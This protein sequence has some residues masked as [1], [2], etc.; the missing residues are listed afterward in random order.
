MSTASA[1]EDAQRA[2]DQAGGRL[3]Y[4]LVKGKAY[5]SMVVEAVKEVE[6][7]RKRLLEVLGEDG[8]RG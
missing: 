6:F 3:V 1:I 8:T 2:L 5:R 7:A 4:M